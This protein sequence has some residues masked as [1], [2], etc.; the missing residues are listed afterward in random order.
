MSGETAIE[1]LIREM[2]P[3]LNSG[4]YVFCSLP[5]DA[6]PAALHPVCLFQEAE[7]T[8]LILPQVEADKLNLSYSFIAAWITLIIHSSLEAIG[9]TAAVSQALAAERISCNIVAAFYHDH[10]FVKLEDGERAMEVLRQMSQ[11]KGR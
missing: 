7:G 9:L 5:P 10:L 2:Q 1:R 11:N 3:K 8:T 4:A 6:I